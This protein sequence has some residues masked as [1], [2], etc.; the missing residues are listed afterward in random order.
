VEKIQRSTVLDAYL[1]KPLYHSISVVI[2]LCQILAKLLK[3]EPKNMLLSG[4]IVVVPE[5]RYI[6]RMFHELP[7]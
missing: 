5:C 1:K 6:A 4:I 2:A 3:K 7:L